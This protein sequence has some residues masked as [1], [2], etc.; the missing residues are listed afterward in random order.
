MGLGRFLR[1][2]F[3]RAK[4]TI[5]NLKNLLK[6]LKFMVVK[7]NLVKHQSGG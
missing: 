1:K 6:N 2:R 3:L 5:N 4:K 7:S